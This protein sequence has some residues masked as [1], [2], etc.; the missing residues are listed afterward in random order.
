MAYPFY[1]CYW[2]YNSKCCNVRN[3]DARKIAMIKSDWPN[4]RC[5]PHIQVLSYLPF[6]TF[7]C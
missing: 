2:Y 6:F 5:K 3:Y 1:V 7:W 4:Q